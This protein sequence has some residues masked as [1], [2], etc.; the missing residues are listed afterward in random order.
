MKFSFFRYELQPRYLPGATPPRPRE[1][2]LIK[3]EWPIQNVIGVADCHPWVEFGDAPLHV[4]LEKLAKGH[5]TPIMEQTVWLAKR[6][7]LARAKKNNL[8]QH[9]PRIR[10]HAIV[11]NPFKIQEG[12][13]AAWRALGYSHLKIKLGID[14]KRE[15][16]WLNNIGKV[17]AFRLRLDFNSKLNWDTFEKFSSSIDPT[18]RTKIEFVEDPMPY[19]YE[20]W[21]RAKSLLPLAVD[22]ESKNVDWD[23]NKF[24]FQF[25]VMKPAVQDV[26]TVVDRATRARKPLIVT[27]YMDHPVGQLHALS[28]AGDLRRQYPNLILDCGLMTQHLYLDTPFT[29]FFKIQGPYIMGV[30]GT[31]IGYDNLLASLPWLKLN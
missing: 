10:N 27:S 1:G 4:Q 22:M 26:Q 7:G 16:D 21:D 23:S 13:F 5:M 25:M 29:P 18:V 11:M 30:D 31:G 17:Q 14:L 9:N 3:V 24:P 6:D 19:V 12:E 8:V 2:A 28:I 20:E 15:I